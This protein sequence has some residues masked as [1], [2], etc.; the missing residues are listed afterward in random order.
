MPTFGYT[1]G[2]HPV[3]GWDTVTL[4]CD[5]DTPTTATFSPQMGC[6]LLSFTVAGQEYL[7]DLDRAGAEPRLLGTPVL[8]PTPNRVRDGVFTY[9]GREFRFTP[10]NGPNFIHGLVREERWQLD[11][12]VTGID[13][14]GEACV[15]A[16][17]R[18]RLSPG[19]PLYDLFPIAN[20]L[21]LTF[22]LKPAEL[23]LRFSVRNDDALQSLPFGLAIHPY[24]AVIG[25]RDE[26]TLRVPATHRME[27]RDLLP[28]GRL[29]P[30]AGTA[31]LAQPTRLSALHLDDV[32]W[33]M[34]PEHPAQIDYLAISKRLTLEAGALFTHAV[35]YT[36]AGQ[37][38]FCIENQSCSTDAH[39]LYARGLTEAAHL[40]ILPPGERL[41]AAIRFRVS[42]L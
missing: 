2:R 6:N 30:L 28:T 40:T 9:A 12:P 35:V 31:D 37:P 24:F 36:P 10:N 32:F 17:A 18:I 11:G 8:Y 4:F 5:G 19:S 23:A 16:T 13:T 15:A 38:F 22:V 33:G 3:T 26:V 7:V 1:T 34:E 29:L 14:L 41:E 27:A 25:G 21:Q 39:N 42:D 20:T